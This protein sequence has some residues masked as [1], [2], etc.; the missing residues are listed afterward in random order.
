MIKDKDTK[1]DARANFSK[2]FLT[3]MITTA[4]VI[5]ISRKMS[6]IFLLLEKCYKF[7]LTWNV[8]P[9]FSWF[10]LRQHQHTHDHSHRGINLFTFSLF[11]VYCLLCVISQ[12]QEYKAGRG[13]APH[14]LLSCVSSATSEKLTI[15]ET[16]LCLIVV[17]KIFLVQ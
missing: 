14:N 6:K 3:K 2:K 7:P 9:F 5:E 10:N 13:G 4:F 12:Y 16:S 8:G 15:L 1:L 17:W 11:Q